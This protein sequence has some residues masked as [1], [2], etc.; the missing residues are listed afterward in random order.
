MSGRVV[1]TGLG[2]VSPNGIGI[3]EFLLAI[4][5]GLSGIR[6]IPQYKELNFNCQV[7]GIPDFEFSQLK[8]YIA[9]TSLHGLKGHGIA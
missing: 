4:Q 2:V 3:P 6:F 9:G 1:I 7:S 5:Q 8:N